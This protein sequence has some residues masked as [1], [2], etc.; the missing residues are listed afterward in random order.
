MVEGTATA[1]EC[2]TII[3]IQFTKECSK[4]FVV[5]APSDLYSCKWFMRGFKPYKHIN[6]INTYTYCKDKL[7]IL[8]NDVKK[9]ATACL[10]SKG[11]LATL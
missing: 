1:I 11:R 6:D 8:I 7:H 3:Q 4:F 10:Q 9:K 2:G 5:L